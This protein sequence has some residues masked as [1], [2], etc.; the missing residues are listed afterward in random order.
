MTLIRIEHPRGPNT[1]PAIIKHAVRFGRRL[2]AHGIHDYE[3]P[4]VV[5]TD[6]VHITVRADHRLVVLDNVGGYR[7]S[8]QGAEVGPRGRMIFDRSAIKSHYNRTHAIWLGYAAEDR[9]C[10]WLD[11]ARKYL[12]VATQDRIHAV[13]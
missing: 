1:A 13:R 8:L 10:G 4:P 2:R 7:P 11:S 9:R 12:N 3:F 5:D 6:A